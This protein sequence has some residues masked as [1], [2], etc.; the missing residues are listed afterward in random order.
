MA[1]SGRGP[2][3]RAGVR[4]TSRHLCLDRRDLPASTLEFRV[5]IRDRQSSALHLPLARRDL[6]LRILRTHARTAAAGSDDATIA[7]RSTVVTAR[8]AAAT[9]FLLQRAEHDFGA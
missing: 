3:C 8:R 6:Q 2:V 7:G 1:A 5:A 9:A 4:R